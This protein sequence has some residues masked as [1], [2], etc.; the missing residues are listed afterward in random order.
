MTPA[1]RN[2][3]NPHA[4]TLAERPR[5]KPFLTILPVRDDVLL[6][7]GPN[8]LLRLSDKGVPMLREFLPLL[9][10]RHTLD[11]LRSKTQDPAA[12]DDVLSTLRAHGL[13]D[14]GDPSDAE[15]LSSDE[16]ARLEPQLSLLSYFSHQPLAL[17]NRLRDAKVLLI[18]AGPVGAFTGQTLQAMGVGR[19]A[20]LDGRQ[21]P[22]WDSHGRAEAQAATSRALELEHAL[23]R[24]PSITKTEVVP[25]ADTTPSQ[26]EHETLRRAIS[27]RSHVLIA[28][29]SPEPEALARVNELALEVGV[30]WTP[31][32]VN[33][34]LATLGPTVIPRKAACWRCYDLRRK[35]ADPGLDRFLVY[36]QHRAR[37]GGPGPARLGFLPSFAPIVGG[38]LAQEAFL[39]ITG[40]TAPSLLG[41]V[42]V[43]DL[44]RVS[45]QRHRVL[46]LPR[47]PACGAADVPDLDRFD[48]EP[49]YA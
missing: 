23:S 6:A 4:T 2:G 10:G 33:G 34:P 12:L 19:L 35:G 28:L 37:H 40:A 39:A 26:I 29:E 21:P 27:G 36:E 8:L 38:L 9:D 11:E 32:E 20:L 5:L 14:L 42:L 18:G 30:P 45:L 41:H 1:G 22:P 43:A 44:P 7:H 31:A 49:V 17:Q 13:L 16:G 25:A 3:K 15:A 47:C 48:L 46:R 24:F